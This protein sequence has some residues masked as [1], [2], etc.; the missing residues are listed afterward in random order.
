MF[1]R[2]RFK[3]RF[4]LYFLRCL[5][6]SAS[7]FGISV[8]KNGSGNSLKKRGGGSHIKTTHY[9]HVRGLPERPPRMHTSQTRSNSSSSKSWSNSFPLLFSP[10]R[11]CFPNVVR[12]GINCKCFKHTFEQ[13]KRIDVENTLLM[14]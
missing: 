10:K 13:M 1:C 3:C 2:L 12:I 14:I 9:E 5:M 8:Q 7:P 4:L 6:P 11:F